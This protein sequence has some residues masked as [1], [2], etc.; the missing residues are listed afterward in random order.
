MKK[1]F[2]RKKPTLRGFRVAPGRF[3]AK[4][5]LIELNDRLKGLRRDD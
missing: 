3:L 2:W 1:K 4:D 5:R